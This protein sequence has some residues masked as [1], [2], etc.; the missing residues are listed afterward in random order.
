M[1]AILTGELLEEL[2]CFKYLGTQVAADGGCERYVKEALKRVLSNR[3]FWITAKKCQ[4]EG[5][6]VLAAFYVAE[7]CEMRSAERRKVL[8]KETL[9]D[10]VF[11]KFGRSVKNI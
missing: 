7:A 11:E 4:Y 6:I 1:H 2:D 9:R 3:G 8:R 10:E 5:V